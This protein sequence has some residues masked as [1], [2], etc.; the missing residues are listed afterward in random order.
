MLYS[1]WINSSA[2]IMLVSTQKHS[3]NMNLADPSVRV[4]LV[5]LFHG[6]GKLK[7]HRFIPYIQ[8]TKAAELWVE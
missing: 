5:A 1:Y 6:L 7:K 8:P 3:N 4:A 2:L